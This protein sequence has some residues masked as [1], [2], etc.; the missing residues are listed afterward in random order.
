[1]VDYNYFSAESI[2]KLLYS[3]NLAMNKNL[4]QNFL[5]SSSKCDEIASLVM[6]NAQKDKEIFEIGPGIG[7]LTS[8]FLKNDYKVKSFEIDKGFA[9]I[10]HLNLACDNLTICEGDALKTLFLEPSCPDVVCGNL[11]YNISAVLISKIIEN[12][13]ASSYPSFMVFLLQKEVAL[14]FCADALSADYSSLSLIRSI[15]YDA[16]IALNIGRHCFFPPPSVDSSIVVFKR[17]E[18]LIGDEVLRKKFIEVVRL[19]FA[20]RRKNIKNNMLFAKIENPDNVLRFSNLSPTLRAEQLK[21]SDFVCI[22]KNLLNI[23]QKI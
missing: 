22:S 2:K 20:K 3:N 17:H 14:R 21:F 11:P 16:N 18:S 15:N 9:R 23:E 13:I 1:M 12:G 8:V 7:A 4:G 5:I 6:T 10:L 19:L